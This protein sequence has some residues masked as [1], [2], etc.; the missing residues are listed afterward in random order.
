MELSQAQI[1]QF[2]VSPKK[3]R[4]K[5][6]LFIKLLPVFGLVL[7]LM[8][9]LLDSMVDVYV[10]NPG[11]SLLEGVLTNDKSEIWMRS[12]FLV[13]FVGFAVLTQ[14]FMRRQ[15]QNELALH[16]HQQERELYLQKLEQ[17]HIDLAHAKGVAE[18]ANK[19]KSL[20]L[21]NVSHELRTPLNA[22]IGYSELLREDL[23]I[24]LKTS[25]YS[26]DCQ[27]I[28]NAG[29]NLLSLI[30]DLLDM[31]KLEASSMEV[32]AEN[33]DIKILLDSIHIMMQPALKKSGINLEIITELGEI[34]A[35]NDASKIKQILL[36]LL[37]NITKI[38]SQAEILLKVEERFRNDARFIDFSIISRSVDLTCASAKY[39][40]GE[41]SHGDAQLQGNGLPRD[42]GDASRKL[43]ALIGGVFSVE[44]EGEGG[45]R[46]KLCVPAKLDL[47]S[48]K[49]GR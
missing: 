28:H 35:V 44:R 14:Y 21:A 8:M 47:V 17:S 49:D 16:Y 43:T 23:E 9:W 22:I 30:N 46:Y 24:D 4:D 19:I 38:V 2:L 13:F 40:N 45:M 6:R 29:L 32:V 26:E 27:R 31:S 10:L 18:K 33:F 41:E 15:Q 5:T 7:G 11:E 12:L 1:S 42:G 37:A 48:N 25:E 20:F 36:G 3:A 39:I 34:H